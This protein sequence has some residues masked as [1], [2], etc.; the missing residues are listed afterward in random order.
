MSDY[1]WPSGGHHHPKAVIDHST[2]LETN[3]NNVL[4]TAESSSP[5]YSDVPSDFRDKIAK[6]IRNGVEGHS[7]RRGFKWS[8]TDK[9]SITK[10][11]LESIIVE[12]DG[13]T[14]GIPLTQ[15]YGFN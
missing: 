5:R 15:F 14:Q 13:G 7:N 1:R 9:G 10:S 3:I 4:N 8:E 6:G 12:T 2:S 11:I